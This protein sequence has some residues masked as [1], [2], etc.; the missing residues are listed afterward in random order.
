[1]TRLNVEGK[2]LARLPV[3]SPRVYA[4]P[5]GTGAPAAPSAPSTADIVAQIDAINRAFSEFRNVNDRAI[6]ELRAGRGDV[7]TAEQVD[8]INAS[9]DTHEQAL[10]DLNRQ[11]AAAQIGGAG[12][13]GGQTAAQKAYTTAFVAAL[14]GSRAGSEIGQHL[15]AMRTSAAQIG[16]PQ[17]ALYS[18]S[19]PDGGFFVPVEMDSTISRVQQTY[20]PMRALASV[21]STTAAAM[22]K[23]H[24]VGGATS[25]WVGE[26]TSRTET[27]TPELSKLTWAT[28]EL[29]AEPR[30][31]QTILDD[32]AYPV[33]QWLADSV[34]ISFSE[35]EGDAWVRGDGVAQPRGY[36][37]YPKV[38][39]ASWAWGKVGFLV[40]GVAA[41]LSDGSN[42][43]VDALINVVT[44]LKP[45]YLPN[46]SWKMSRATQGVVRKLKDGDSNY[47]WQ[48][49]AQ[50]GIPASL[51]GYP[52]A[53]DDN[54]DAIGANKFPIGFA[55]WKQAFRIVDRI[56]IRVLPD[57]YTAKPYVKF[58]TTKRVGGGIEDFEAIKLLKCST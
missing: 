2:A 19:D 6:A 57:P 22:E 25:G 29:Y 14:R 13:G 36:L 46:A 51:L 44:A 28:Y 58:Y 12:N 45:A 27:N 38:A 9:I 4:G 53:V 50:A 40:T 32:A 15:E 21:R 16:G 55:D 7:L 20:S 54:E 52:V 8:R 33:Q 26:R 5:D 3:V 35:K 23:L 37:S 48:P 42:N 39:D 1:M 41:A 30:A 10:G 31:T 49:G 47:L 17:A 11:L 43:G 18:S 56:G 24:D 34:G